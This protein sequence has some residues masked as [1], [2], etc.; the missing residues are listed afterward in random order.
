VRYLAAVLATVSLAACQ[1]D[2]SGLE[3]Q[4][5]TGEPAPPGDGVGT[6]DPDRLEFT[7]SNMQLADVPAPTADLVIAAGQRGELDTS[8]VELRVAG[9]TV[10]AA[11][12][13]ITQPGALDLVIVSL[14]E[15]R[16]EANGELEI[17]GSRPLAIV[18]TGTVRVSGRVLASAKGTDGGPG[19][20]TAG[21]G[22]GQAG[23]A[24]LLVNGSYAGA[25][26]GGGGFASAGGDGASLLPLGAP[27]RG[28]DVNGTATL[29]PLRGG[30]PGGNGGGTSGGQGGGGG[31]AI[32]ISA[33]SIEIAQGGAIAAAGAGGRGATGM[34]GGGG[35]GGSGGAI[36]LEAPVLRLRGAILVG[37]GGGG[38][39]ARGS[40]DGGS[41]GQDGRLDG[42]PATGGTDKS[43]GGGDGGSGAVAQTAAGPGQA[44]EA[45]TPV[46]GGG[47]GGGGGAGRVHL[48]VDPQ[49][50]VE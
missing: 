17:R 16:I 12:R 21:C 11:T 37:G 50:E 23:T 42:M 3:L 34:Y 32:Q 46:L 44:G 9:T 15:L 47:G 41:N 7:P 5:A 27:A 24:Q 35:G 19:A 14:R 26:G 1:F 6:E 25:G 49:P 22:T 29:V 10:N 36:L 40:P 33:R 31:G 45:Q 28:G 43:A 4:P 8:D 13:V 38:E 39:G 30:C 20:A 18:V 2:G 48:G